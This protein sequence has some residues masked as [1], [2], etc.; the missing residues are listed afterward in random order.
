MGEDGDTRL[1]DVG[2]ETGDF[3][4]GIGS[5]APL[6]IIF[7]GYLNRGAADGRAAFDGPIHAASNRHVGTKRRH[8]LDCVE[9]IF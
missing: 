5:A 2:F 4:G 6:E 7:Q 1:R 9:G 8:T 3:I